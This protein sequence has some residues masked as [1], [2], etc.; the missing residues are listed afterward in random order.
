MDVNKGGVLETNDDGN[1]PFSKFGFDSQVKTENLLKKLQRDLGIETMTH[2]QSAVIPRI[3]KSHH[4][5]MQS[6]TETEEHLHIH[7]HPKSAT[8]HGRCYKGNN[9]CA[10]L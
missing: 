2:V 10:N 5:A 6:C 7:Y 4:I 9:Y 1:D 8:Y 3:T